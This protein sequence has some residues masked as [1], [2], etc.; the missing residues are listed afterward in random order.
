MTLYHYSELNEVEQHEVLWDRGVMVGDRSDGEHNIL[1]YQMFSF[2][3]ELYYNPGSIILKKLR[4]FSNVRNLDVYL[5]HIDI[6]AI[7][8]LLKT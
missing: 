4:G 1:L 8:Y 2:Y 6:S 7:G 3:V 5:R